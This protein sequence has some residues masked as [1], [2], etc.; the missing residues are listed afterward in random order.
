MGQCSLL[1]CGPLQS[2]LERGIGTTLLEA[3][4]GR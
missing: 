1:H 3:F 4:A 2:Y